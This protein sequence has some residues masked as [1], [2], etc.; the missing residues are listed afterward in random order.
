MFL[1][2]ASLCFFFTFAF[3]VLPLSV[4]PQFI[5]SEIYET[6]EDLLE[7]LQRGYLT[8]D[9]YLELLDM[10][11][12]KLHPASEEADRLF[13]VPDVSSLDV[14]QVKAKD[15]G[16]DLSQKVGSFLAEEKKKSRLPFS[17]RLVWKLYQELVE[18]GDAENYLLCQVTNGRRMIWHIEADQRA[19]SSS[20]VLSSGDLRVR[21]RSLRLLLPEYASEVILGNF[22]KRI[23]L[24]LNVG[25]HPLLGYS[26]R[27]DFKPEDSFLYPA[28]GRYNGI[29]GES[30]LKSFTMVAFYSRNKRQEIE[31]RIGAFD[32]SFGNKELNAGL[33]FSEGE[34]RNVE[35]G[36]I[37]ADD[38]RSLHFDLKLKPVTFSGEYA[39][40]P[41]KKSGLAIELYSSR[42]SYSF[43]LSWWRYEDQFVHP[44]GGG[45]SNPDYESIYLDD[46]DYTYRSRQAGE[47]GVFFKSRYTILRRLSLDFSYSQ[48]REKSDLPDK[49]KLRLG[50]GYKFSRDFSCTIYQLWT[51]YRVDDK[52]IDRRTS[53][54]NL[55]FSPHDQL[56]FNLIANYR[57][58]LSKD[59]GDL[60]LKI[61]TRAISP[62]DFILWLKYYDPNFSLS[63]DGYLSFHLQETLRF[64]EN[65]FVSAEYIAKFY[66]NE[67]K[68]GSRAVRIRVETFW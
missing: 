15:Q 38:C 68:V 47:R 44:H 36:T 21:K 66:Q 49:M 13:F 57:N 29:Y 62:F 20:V 9:Q 14:L 5:S 61:G 51:D 39:L 19:D 8:L 31:N 53:S 2:T 46:I 30:K 27:S 12:G 35:N 32:L 7:G 23:G 43:D 40:L 37:L 67:N 33:C 52:L 63:S 18:E 65:C 60:R 11:Q 55:F 6:E 26:T 22:D 42:K 1:K 48:W 16:V 54:L 17:G 41:G 10:I 64:F 24:G 50:S 3:W 56:D 59:Y 45:V 58:T 28:L 4:Q 34:L 25:Y